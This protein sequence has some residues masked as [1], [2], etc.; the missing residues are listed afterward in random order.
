ME[1]PRVVRRYNKIARREHQRLKLAPR[2]FALQAAI[3]QDS[4]PTIYRV[5]KR[6]SILT[7][8]PDGTPTSTVASSKWEPY[9]IPIACIKPE[10]LLICGIFYNA[11]N[12]ASELAQQKFGAL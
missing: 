12:T 10:L 1:D 2:A 6:S 4:N 9:P 7:R 11:S 8:L 5:M 3:R